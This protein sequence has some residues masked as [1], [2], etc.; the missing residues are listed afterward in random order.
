[1]ENQS[2]FSFGTGIALAYIG[3]VIFMLGLVYLCVKQTDLHLVTD[4][5]YQEELAYQSRIDQ[6]ENARKLSI[7][8]EVTIEE[9][10]ARFVFPVESLHGTG[11]VT[12]Y[13]PSNPSADFE[14]PFTINE[15]DVRLSLPPHMA[16]GLWNAEITWVKEGVTYYFDQKFQK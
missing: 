4:Q 10:E 15:T 3:F 7:L 16:K 1:M 12:F 9:T 8:P 14:V 11:Q 2:S 5:Y 13:R 6:M